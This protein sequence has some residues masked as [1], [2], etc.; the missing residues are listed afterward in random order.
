CVP[1]INGM[2]AKVL[3]Q[4]GNFVTIGAGLFT[5]DDKIIGPSD[6]EETI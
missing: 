2:P 4:E 5:E 6:E 3:K 1:Y